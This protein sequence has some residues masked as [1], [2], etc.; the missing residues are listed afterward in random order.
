VFKQ[1]TTAA[2]EK[3]M[4]KN[5]LSIAGKGICK[6]ADKTSI[7][8]HAELSGNAPYFGTAKTKVYDAGGALVDETEE[9]LAL[10][11]SMMKRS[12]LNKKLPAGTYTVEVSMTPRRTDI[13]SEMI[14][15]GSSSDQRFT[16][17]LP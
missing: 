3:G 17:V 10:Y 12:T 13:P 1:V 9:T 11:V 14:D 15:Y 8:W 6:T 16:I 2:Y 5:S 4:M 7:L